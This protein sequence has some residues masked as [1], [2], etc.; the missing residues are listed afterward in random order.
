MPDMSI[1]S[2]MPD[3]SIMSIMSDMSKTML[4]VR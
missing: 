2:N 1:M 4:I 3:M